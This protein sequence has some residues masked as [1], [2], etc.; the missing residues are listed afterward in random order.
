MFLK[1]AA[2]FFIAAFAFVQA[3]DSSSEVQFIPLNSL[4]E[5]LEEETPYGLPRELMPLWDSLTIKQKAAQMVMVY[6]TPADF[7]LKNEFGGYL[8]MKTHLKH[9]DKFISLGVV[10]LE[11]LTDKRRILFGLIFFVGKLLLLGLI[12]A[13]ALHSPKESARYSTAWAST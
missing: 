3:E 7:M 4:T 9:L 13:Q 11:V 10:H 12:S 5:S 8:V 2:I 1:R 6:M